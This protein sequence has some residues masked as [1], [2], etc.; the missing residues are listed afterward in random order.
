MKK[1]IF[2]VVALFSLMNLGAVPASQKPFDIT[3]PDGTIVTLHMIGDEY[4]HWTETS[5]NQ[6]VIQSEEGYY[7]YATIV[8]DEIV[9]SGVKVSNTIGDLQLNRH[10]SLPNREQLVDLMMNK[11]RTIIA[12]LDSLAH[13]EDSSDISLNARAS[14]NISLTKGNQKVL[15]VLIAFPDRSFTKTKAD[16][17]N[18]WN[19]TGYNV[20]G[21]SGS[22]KDFYYENS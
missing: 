10:T 19:Q 22:I 18:M 15:C 6:V 13:A 11:R 5:D 1:I 20:E 2:L 7:E 4:Y 16:F 8:N 21:S 3:Q 17:Q 14:S 12:H 9:P